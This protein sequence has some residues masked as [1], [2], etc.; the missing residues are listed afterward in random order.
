MVQ[1]VSLQSL[2]NFGQQECHYFEF[3][4]LEELKIVEKVKVDQGARVS[5][6]E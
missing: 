1:I 2:I 4:S 5:W 3:Q 6:P